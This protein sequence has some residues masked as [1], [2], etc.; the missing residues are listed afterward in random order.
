VLCIFALLAA[1]AVAALTWF[2]FQRPISAIP[3]LLLAG[4]GWRISADGES[5]R[6]TP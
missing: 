3:L 1:G 4:R 5:E 2:P 6:S